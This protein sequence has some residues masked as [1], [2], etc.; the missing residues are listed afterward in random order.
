LL[1]ASGRYAG[2]AA[3]EPTTNPSAAAPPPPEMPWLI[4]HEDYGGDLGSRPALT[5]TWGGARQSLMDN[6]VRFDLSSSFTVQGN[7]ANGR[8]NHIGT[9]SN[10]L[11]FDLRVDTGKAHLWPGGIL[12]IKAQGNFGTS[13]NG[14]TGTLMPVNTEALFPSEPD[15]YLLPEW[16]FTQFLSPQL[17]VTL[18]KFS[19]REANVFAHDETEQFMNCA[20]NFNPVAATTVPLSTLGAGVIL[21]PTPDLVIATMALD[22]E[23]T[24]ES[25]GFDTMFKRGTTFM[26]SYELA[27]HPADRIGHQR[28]GWTYSDR[29]RVQFAQNPREIVGA[30]VTGSTAGLSRK[31]NDWSVFYDFDQYLYVVPGSVDRGWGVFGRV[32]LGD[33]Q[34]NLTHSFYSFGVGGKG[35]L[36][37][38]PDDTFGVAFYYLNVTDNLPAPLQA[39]ARDEY[40][41]EM[42]YNFA[43]TPWLHVTPDLQVIEPASRRT[44]TTVVAGVRARMIF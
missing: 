7:V 17:A 21:V 37:A 20:F 15:T 27:I 13:A 22:S 25:A 35:P 40:G 32:G 14:G 2:A 33:D 28:I 43:V 39:R 3:A 42:Y 36:D 34:V 12:K 1:A 11:E 8:D 10:G 38:R 19:P 26:Q 5:G 30:I 4:P 24:A 23:G 31:A 44:N 9:S 6:G 18:G 41:V 16:N 29:S